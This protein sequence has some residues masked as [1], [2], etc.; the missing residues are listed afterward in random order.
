MF[1]GAVILCLNAAAV[2]FTSRRLFG[3]FFEREDPG[4]ISRW[5]WLALVSIGQVVLAGLL[6]GYAGALTPLGYLAFHGLSC[7]AALRVPPPPTQIHDAVPAG[8]W[9]SQRWSTLQ[10]LDRAGLIFIAAT[11]ALY[12]ATGLF[13]ERLVHDALTYR[14]SRVAHWLQE[15]SIRHFSTNEV[16]QNYHSINADLVIAWFMAPFARGYPLAALPQ[17]IGGVMALLATFGMARWIG[18]RRE[19]C[20]GALVLLFAMPCLVVQWSTCQ[21]DLF[22]TGLLWA[23]LYFFAQSPARHRLAIPAWLGVALAIGAKGTVF[24]LGPALVVAGLIW[25]RSG[26]ATGPCWKLHLASGCL[27]LLVFAAPRY[28]ENALHYGN[29]FAPKDVYA[30]NHG[31]AENTRWRAKL[32]LNLKSCLIQA[33]EPASNIPPL[34]SLLQNPWRSMIASLPESDPYSNTHY[35]RKEWIEVFGRPENAGAD[36]LT[37][38]ALVPLLAVAGWLVALV[39]LLRHGGVASRQLVTLGLIPIL[40]LLFF[41]LMFLWW[42]TSFRYFALLAPPLA[43]LAGRLFESFP[44]PARIAALT[45]SLLASLLTLHLA[46]TQPRNAGWAQWRP[47]PSALAY[48]DRIDA[49][50]RAIDEFLPDGSRAG[51][52]LDWNQPLTGFYRNRHR[53]R[54]RLIEK[55][56]LPAPPDPQFL[57][58]EQL[59]AVISDF[60]RIPAPPPGMRYEIVPDATGARPVYLIHRADPAARP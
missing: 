48:L 34:R 43:I 37:T 60:V 30:L 7:L 53:V 11:L 4:R 16:R 5:L 14:L 58:R 28:L 13:G 55:A 23:G 45:L 27:C 10:W 1:P 33:I 18:L 41:N 8:R 42:P 44:A 49:A 12:L 17:F 59:D 36:S 54:I 25:L 29:P 40:F 32:G 9:L 22:T 15:H 52:Y 19:S 21:S 6:L 20:V 38:G 57:R 2:L 26:R 39:R 46:F 51:V 47:D 56:E 3:L 35:P 31:D 24:Y 50:R